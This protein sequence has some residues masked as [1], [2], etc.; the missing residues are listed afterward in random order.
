MNSENTR[1]AGDDLRSL[2]TL[3]AEPP[4]EPSVEA[5]RNEVERRRRK[6]LLTVAGEVV[7]TLCLIA[8]SAA[9]LAGG[10]DAPHRVTAVVLLWVTW[11]VAAGFATWNRRGLW[12]SSGKTA[13]GYLALL[14]ERARRRRRVADFVL[15]LVILQLVLAF[16]FG[17]IEWLGGAIVA[18][19]VGWALWYRRRATGDL[20]R[21][22]GISAELRAGDEPV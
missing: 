4:R 17:M 14:E 16:L 22:R 12:R 21:I 10:G 9:L 19:Y 13:L 15:G 11:L 7:F 18:L 1:G 2:W 8:V 5:L 6:M 20:V 3:E